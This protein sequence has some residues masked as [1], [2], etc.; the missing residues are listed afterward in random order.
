[1]ILIVNTAPRIGQDVADHA[2]ELRSARIP[3]VLAQH[4]GAELRVRLGQHSLGGLVAVREEA[5]Q[6]RMESGT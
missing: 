6:C 4:Q 5:G 3:E 1:M 2:R